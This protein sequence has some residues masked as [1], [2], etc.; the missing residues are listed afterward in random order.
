MRHSCTQRMF[1]PAL[2]VSSQHPSSIL[3]QDSRDLDLSSKI[4]LH[5]SI[6]F[7]FTAGR[8]PAQR[9]DTIN[10]QCCDH[11][12]VNRCTHG[13][14]HL[15]LRTKE[16]HDSQRSPLPAYLSRHL[17]RSLLGLYIFAA[18]LTDVAGATDGDSYDI[19]PSRGELKSSSTI[20]KIFA[21]CF[22]A[23]ILTTED[24]YNGGNVS[25][26]QGLYAVVPDSNS[27]EGCLDRFSGCSPGI[28]AQEDVFA[29]EA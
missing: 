4:T 28:R 22:I 27:L 12:R 23:G 24:T 11:I 2:H 9:T 15:S 1:T 7:I 10:S 21:H 5:Y 19:I 14:D 18:I 6:Q 29:V 25:L 13:D 20:F 17:S 26:S 3:G 16:R 8:P